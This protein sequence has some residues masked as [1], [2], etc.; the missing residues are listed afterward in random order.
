MVVFSTHEDAA[1]RVDT[2]QAMQAIEGRN[3][4]A[5]KLKIF[6]ATAALAITALAA[7]AANAGL[8]VSSAESCDAQQYSHPF[9]K[10]GDNATYT[11]APGGAFESGQ[12]GW[13]L[14]GGAKAVTGNESFSV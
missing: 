13:T 4:M 8:L 7:P 11:P 1:S 2:C 12:N 3:G 9:S 5:G 14:T 6:A 10:W